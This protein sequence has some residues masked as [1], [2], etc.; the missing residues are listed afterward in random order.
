M[1][2]IITVKEAR[3]LSKYHP[4]LEGT[5]EELLE[6]IEKFIK[7]ECNRRELGLWYEVDSFKY[8]YAITKKAIK[9]LKRKGYKVKKIV[10]SYKPNRPKKITLK[11]L[12]W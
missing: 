3:E 11:I 9:I 8:D 5:L 10:D 2:N 1:S 4:K 7:E 6:N 12:W